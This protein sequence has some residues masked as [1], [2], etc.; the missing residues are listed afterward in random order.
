MPL[1]YKPAPCSPEEIREIFDYDIH[2]GDLIWKKKVGIRTKVGAKAG[3]H[4]RN[5]KIVSLNPWGNF[6]AHR[7]VWFWYYGVWPDKD[8]DH[9]N[10]DPTDN[11]ISNLRSCTRSENNQNV[12]VSKNNS[13]GFLGVQRDVR[14]RCNLARQWKATIM[15]NRKR[16]YLGRFATPEEAHAAYTRAKAE[17]HTFQPVPRK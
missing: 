11:R 13:H 5:Y 10:G 1:Q 6:A 7:L 3:T 12:R 16:H 2:S 8:L 15:V 17:L 14:P 4:K 9:A